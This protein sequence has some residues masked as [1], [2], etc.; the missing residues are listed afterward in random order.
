MFSRK[1]RF[2]STY[3]D[4]TN[5][6][7]HFIVIFFD[8]FIENCLLTDRANAVAYARGQ[9]GRGTGPIVYDDLVCTGSETDLLY[10]QHRGLGQSDCSH[11]E[12]AGV[13]CGKPCKLNNGISNVLSINRLSV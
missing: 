6:V 11:Y 7:V 1:I 5:F 8:L 9:F 12:D 13:K 2:V 3:K 10:C 4:V